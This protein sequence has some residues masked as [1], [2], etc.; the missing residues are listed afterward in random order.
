MNTNDFPHFYKVCRKVYNHNA[1]T[2]P[3]QGISL[4]V[5]DN[6]AKLFYEIGKETIAKVGPIFVFK[7][8]SAAIRWAV[9]DNDIIFMGTGEVMRM[10]SDTLILEGMSSY[11]TKRRIE[12]YWKNMDKDRKLRLNLQGIPGFTVFLRNFTPLERIIIK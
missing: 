1:N 11:L 6:K 9:S 10:S 12:Y 3:T 4:Y 8:L 2:I 7:D 5:E